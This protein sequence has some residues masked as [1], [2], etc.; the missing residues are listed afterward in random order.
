MLD[1]DNFEVHIID[2]IMHMVFIHFT[3]TA[4]FFVLI[5]VF[6]YLLLQQDIS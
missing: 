1:Q 6:L 5:M 2:E 3:F 4:I